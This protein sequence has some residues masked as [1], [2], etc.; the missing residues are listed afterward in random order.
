MNTC[1]TCRHYIGDFCRVAFALGDPEAV[2]IY[3]KPGDT[4]ELWK[5]DDFRPM[6]REKY[7]N[8]PELRQPDGNRD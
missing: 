5:P 8:L 2:L 3:V 6:V 4:C 7:E 1:K